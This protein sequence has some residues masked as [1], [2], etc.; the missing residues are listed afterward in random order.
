MKRRLIMGAIKNLAILLLLFLFGAGI[1]AYNKFFSGASS[2]DFIS[3]IS[4]NFDSIYSAKKSSKLKKMLST[5]KVEQIKNYGGVAATAELSCPDLSGPLKSFIKRD[6]S[7]NWVTT[8][9]TTFSLIV[10]KDEEEK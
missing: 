2:E 4:D 3:A 6:N 8:D 9:E 1:F 7:G 5:C 10:N